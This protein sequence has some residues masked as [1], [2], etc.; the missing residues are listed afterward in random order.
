MANNRPEN[1]RGAQ[2]LRGLGFVPGGIARAYP[3]INGT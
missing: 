2:L 1:E 3:K